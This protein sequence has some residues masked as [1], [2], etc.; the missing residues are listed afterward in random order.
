MASFNKVILIGNMVADPELKKT[1]S[2]VPV[3]TYRIAVARKFA[4]EG[5]PVQADFFD[6]VCWRTQAEFVTRY[7][8]KGMPILICG[9][10]QSRNW[11]DKDE[12]KRCSIEVVADEVSFVERK[13]QAPQ[14]AT[15]EPQAEPQA[16]ENWVD[17]STEDSLPF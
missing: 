7:F 6:I 2:G 1:P 9:V 4:K 11:T 14:G 16:E 12:N 8:T 10:L 3:T 5:D 17:V 13:G 15:A